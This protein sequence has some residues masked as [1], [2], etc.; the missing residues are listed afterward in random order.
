MVERAEREAGVGCVPTLHVEYAQRRM[1][2]GILFTFS[3]FGEY[4]NLE[5]VR[6][7]GMYK[8]NQAEY[9]IRIL[10]AVPQE[11]V[12]TYSTHRGPRRLLLG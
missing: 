3:L 10:V 8:V 12:N 1:K 11:Y 5:Y 9:A 6:I 4:S 2:F 7:H